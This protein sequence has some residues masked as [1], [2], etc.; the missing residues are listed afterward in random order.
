MMKKA[1]MMNNRKRVCR[2][3]F[4][5]IELLVVIAVIAIL[6]GMLLPALQHAKLKAQSILCLSNVKSIGLAFHGYFSDYSDWIP[7]TTDG[8]GTDTTWV[9]QMFPY[10]NVKPASGT[11]ADRREAVRKAKIF[12]C[13][14]DQHA[15]KCEFWGP[16]HLS[17]GMNYMLGTTCWE[18]TNMP[19][20]I[21]VQKVPFPTKH[22]L[23][24]DSADRR[25][26]CTND[27][28]HYTAVAQSVRRF[29]G[30]HGFYS[31]YVTLGGNAYTIKKYRL[32]PPVMDDRQRVEMPWNGN[33]TLTPMHGMNGF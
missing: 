26:E 33:L 2:F 4:T 31:N 29:S 7:L 13:P 9:V 14:A 17:Y 12:T 11:I 22:L 19:M 21:K 16:R 30:T 23:A 18:N 24:V 20:P 10:L 25:E 28:D 5:L 32:H 15:S 1:K 3:H 8:S 27:Y 6:A